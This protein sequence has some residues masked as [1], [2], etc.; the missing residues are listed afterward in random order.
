MSSRSPVSHARAK[1]FAA[2]MEFSINFCIGHTTS[3]SKVR[4]ARMNETLSFIGLVRQPLQHSCREGE[5]PQPTDS[6]WHMETAD[7]NSSLRGLYHHTSG[8]HDTR[9]TGM[10]IGS[11]MIRSASM[12]MQSA[13]LPVPVA[14]RTPPVPSPYHQSDPL[15]RPRWRPRQLKTTRSVPA[16]LPATATRTGTPPRSPS[17]CSAPS[18]TPTPSASGC[19][20]GPSSTTTRLRRW[21]RWWASSGSSP[22]SSPARSSALPFSLGEAFQGGRFTP[23]S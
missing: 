18:S 17:Y 20:T 8:T 11:T 10:L 23:S 14:R 9:R 2:V 6:G 22:S 1:T 4:H 3:T 15:R 13:R 19:T 12:P 5:N 21:L 7:L 16:S